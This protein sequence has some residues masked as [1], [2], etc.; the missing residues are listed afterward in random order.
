VK[1]E[2]LVTQW[3]A[4]GE[5]F[6]G[7][8]HEIGKPTQKFLRLAAAAEDAGSI[9]VTA[10]KEERTVMTAAVESQSDSEAAYAKAQ[11]D[12]SWHGGNYDQFMLEVEQGLRDP[13]EFGPLP[14]RETYIAERTV[15]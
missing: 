7:G 13:D 11:R 8:V 5:T 2:V 10:S 15:S 6:G 3:T 9:K 1:L 4:E 14:D 12:G